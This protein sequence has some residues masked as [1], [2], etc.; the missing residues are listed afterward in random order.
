MYVRKCH[1]GPIF[2]SAG[3]VNAWA[4]VL[5][6]RFIP[7]SVSVFSFRFSHSVSA[8]YPDLRCYMQL[9]SQRL[10]FMNWS[11]ERS[12]ERSLAGGGGGG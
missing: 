8:F 1:L 3:G 2:F 7:I 4:G 5:F 12:L 9:V 10:Y 6:Q 11:Q